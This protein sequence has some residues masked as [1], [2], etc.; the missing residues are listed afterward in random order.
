M[1]NKIQIGLTSLIVLFCLI[2]IAIKS[3]LFVGRRVNQEERG[4]MWE[5]VKFV[6]PAVIAVMTGIRI[7]CGWFDIDQNAYSDLYSD[8]YLYFLICISSIV[9]TIDSYK[10]YKRKEEEVRKKDK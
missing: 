3:Y 1:N 6:L 5:A 7:I 2:L 4:L 10:G 8:V 9:D